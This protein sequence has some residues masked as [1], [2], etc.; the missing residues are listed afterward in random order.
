MRLCGSERK[1]YTSVAIITAEM[2]QSRIT[3]SS[4]KDADPGTSFLSTWLSY[5]YSL[6]AH[7]IKY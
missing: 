7:V 5:L 3:S 6:A 4:F 2:G 1:L